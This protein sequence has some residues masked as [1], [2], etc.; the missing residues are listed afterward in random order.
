[1]ADYFPEEMQYYPYNRVQAYGT[2]P[3]IEMIPY[4]IRNYL[5]DMPSAGYVPPD[6][7][8]SYRCCLMKY[9]YHDCANPLSQPLPTP[10]QKL[11]L[12]YDPDKP[13]TPPI[14]KGYRIFTQQLVSQAQT[15]GVSTL[16]IYMGR[17]T[18]ISPYS[19]HIS[20]VIDCLTNNDYESNT[21]G[22]DLSRT[23]A[24]ACMCERALSG[25]DMGAGVGAFI[26]D[27]RE[28]NDCSIVMI[29]DESVNIGYRL[30]M[31]MTV[32]GENER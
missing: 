20:V 31:G 9:L 17:V 25:V 26:F 11:A 13:G 6:N 19:A 4:M 8:A 30:T 28:H 3:N 15:L 1:M 5:M 27:R 22:T 7:N 23:Y 29:S 21:R 12:V 10:E 2:L 18:P 16:R 24:M 32:I 14:D